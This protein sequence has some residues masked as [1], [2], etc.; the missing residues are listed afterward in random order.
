MHPLIVEF[1]KSQMKPSLPRL[2]V[3]DTVVVSKLI[4][5]GK[6]QRVQRFQGTV[7]KFQGGYSRKTMTVRR[8]IDGVGVEKSYLLH[9]PLVTDIEVIQLAKVRR[10][11]LYY[12]RGRIGAKA[13]RLKKIDVNNKSH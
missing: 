8:I 7:I 6:K 2:R 1:E 3:G 13:N 9:S 12:L 11:K 5:E 4:N 10:A